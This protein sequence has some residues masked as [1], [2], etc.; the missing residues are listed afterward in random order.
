MRGLTCLAELHVQVNV[1]PQLLGYGSTSGDPEI[2]AELPAH[3]DP[4]RTTV[5]ITKLHKAKTKDAP[6]NKPYGSSSNNVRSANRD[7]AHPAAPR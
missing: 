3:V 7:T 1:P 4:V 2:R 6:A 5:N